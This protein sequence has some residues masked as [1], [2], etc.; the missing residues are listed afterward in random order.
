MFKNQILFGVRACLVRDA[1]LV[2]AL[3]ADISVGQRLSAIDG[4]IMYHE[5]PT[6]FVQH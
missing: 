1:T 3:D 5:W 4:T 2:R 6:I